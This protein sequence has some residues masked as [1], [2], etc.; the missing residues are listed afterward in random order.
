MAS[1]ETVDVSLGD[2]LCSVGHNLSISKS[3]SFSL[4]K[5]KPL[6]VLPKPVKK[7]AVTANKDRL[8]LMKKTNV[9]PVLPNR[10]VE[11]EREKLCLPN[12]TS[13]NMKPIKVIFEPDR[14]LSKS[15]QWI[16]L[17]VSPSTHRLPPRV[18]D[19]NAARLSLNQDWAA[20]KDLLTLLDFARTDTYLSGSE[21]VK[22]THRTFRTR[23]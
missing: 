7:W 13:L 17:H 5:K 14:E 10:S 12:K 3:C 15:N 16:L 22:E 23:I 1:E 8:R 20:F 19:L 11:A 9:S 6:L 18:N 4:Q 21:Q 2:L